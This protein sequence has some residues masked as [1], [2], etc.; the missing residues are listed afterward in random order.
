MGLEQKLGLW[1]KVKN[2]KTIIY[3]T[4]LTTLAV[5]TFSNCTI[6]EEEDNKPDTIVQL[7]KTDSN[8]E[9]KS[10]EPYTGEEFTVSVSDETTKKPIAGAEIID[11]E[12]DCSKEKCFKGFII[13]AGKDYHPQA[14]IAAHHSDHPYT[15]TSN[16]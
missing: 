15:L 9:A 10:T 2:F 3:L 8:G 12:Q 16:L 7:L 11:L 14:E 5:P 13:T 4:A 1:D 6:P